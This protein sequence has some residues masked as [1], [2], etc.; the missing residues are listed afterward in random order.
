ML[1][2][3]YVKDFILIDHV[4]LEFDAHM[5]AFTGE[6]GAGKSLLMDAIGVLKGERIN[7]SMVK[8]GKKKAIIEGVFTISRTH[9]IYQQLLDAGYELEDQQLI[10][11]R[12]CS[13]EGKSSA[14]I[15][16]RV[17]TIGF[18]RDIVSQLVDI[19]SQHDTQYL[20]NTRY[21]ISLL[22]RFCNHTTLLETVQEAWLAYKKLDEA[23]KAALQSDF[24][25]DDLEFL[26]FQLNEI[27]EAAIQEQELDDIEQQLKRLGAFEKISAHLSGAMEYLEGEQGSNPSL[28]EAYREVSG[29]HEDETFVALAEKLLEAYYMVEDV[30]AQLNDYADTME[31][32]EATFTALQERSF[33]IHRLYRKYGGSYAALME[34][35]MDLDRR[36]DLILHRQDYIARQETLCKQAYAAFQKVATTLHEARMKQA[37]QLEKLVVSQLQDLKLTHARFQIQIEATSG[38]ATGIDQVAFLVSM[39]AGERLKNLSTTA[40]GGE[41]SRFMLGLKTV[42][43]RLQGIDT[44]IFDEIDTGVSGQVAFA[45][46]KKM[47]E[48]A[49]ETQV[50]CVTHLAA[51]AA[52]ADQH[53]IV[54]KVQQQQSS[55]T[56]IRLLEGSSRVEELALISS[57]SQSTSALAAAKELLEKA[58]TN[59]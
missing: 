52:C 51:V 48:L 20:L 40:S 29:I 22:D 17:V 2:Q 1:T 7:A 46:G 49:K 23:L 56:L 19:H 9:P 18:L 12:E 21:H 24:N 37:R 43:T 45:I 4:N 33:L 36:I 16:Q 57:N 59:S 25:E 26:T 32:D 13:S 31:Y 47:Q 14:R 27:D 6:T 35:R 30:G 42:F 11:T 34:K 10:V 55:E 8:E 54:E 41:L 53:Y 15:N 5:S 58:R 44:V 28:Y 38:N 3:I 39:N 50:F